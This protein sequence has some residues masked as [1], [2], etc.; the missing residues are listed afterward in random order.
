MPPVYV[1][2]CAC[3]YVRA[4]YGH[5]GPCRCCGQTSW[6][7]VASLDAAAYLEMLLNAEPAGQV[8]SLAETRG[9]IPA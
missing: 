4:G 3:G 1:H 7:H 9:G 8:K 5:V 6:K 2:V